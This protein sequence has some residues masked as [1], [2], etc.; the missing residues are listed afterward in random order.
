MFQLKTNTSYIGSWNG[1][2]RVFL[3]GDNLSSKNLVVFDSMEDLRVFGKIWNFLWYRK[4][5]EIWETNELL[6]FFNNN[7][8]VYFATRNIFELWTINDYEINKNSIELTRWEDYNP[9]DLIKKLADFSFKFSK[10]LSSFGSYNREWDIINIRPT[11]EDITI[12]ISFFW[13]EV[14]EV[15]VFDNNSGIY[16]K[17]DKIKISAKLVE[18]KTTKKKIIESISDIKKYFENSKI[19]LVS[20]D[21]YEWIETLTS[22]FEPIILRDTPTD[23]ATNLWITEL[24]ITNI[25]ELILTLKNP[26]KKKIYTK[27]VRTITNFIEYNNIS[28]DIE[29]VEIPA[30][31]RYLESFASWETLY[32]CDDILSDIFIKKRSRK[33]VAKNIDLLLEIKPWDCIVHIDHWVGVFKQIILKELGWIKREYVEIEYKWNDKLFVPISELHRIS[34]YIWKDNPELTWLNS[35]QWQK[36]IKSTEVEVERIAKELLEIYAKRNIVKW[37]AFSSFEDKEEE[38]RKSFPYTYTLDQETCIREILSDMN[39]SKPM[40]RLLVGDVWFGKTEVAMNAIYRSFLNKK[41]TA[42]ISPLVILAYEH[43]ESLKKRFT[44]FGV[45]IEILTRV[46]TTREESQVLKQLASWEIDCVIWTHRLLSPDIEFKNLGLIIIDEEHRF[47]VIDKEKLNKMRLWETGL[48]SRPVSRP[49]PLDILSLSATPIPRSLNFALNGIKD[50]SIISTPPPKKKPIKTLVAKWSDEIIT[51]SIDSELEK[52]WQVLFIHNRVATIEST[53]N[54][55]EKLLGKK[56]KIVTVH[57]QMN[58]IEVEDRIIDFRNRKYNILLSTTVIENGVNFY[59]ANTIII[60]WADSFWLSQLHQLRWRVWRWDRESSCYL[61][62]RKEWIPDDA[63]KRLV[64]IVNNS[65]LGAW[66]EI[67]MRDLEIRWAWD[68]L[69]IKQSGKSKETW[70]SLYIKLLEDKIEELKTWEKSRWIN[71]QIELNISYYISEDFFNTEAD[72]IHFFRNIESIE[73]LE[74]LEYAYKTFVEWNDKIPEEFNNLFL[75]LKTRIILS[76][77]WIESLKKVWQS[78]IF[79]LYKNTKVE[80]IKEFL[81]KFDIDDNFVLIT[82]HKIKVATEFY[83]SDKDFIDRIINAS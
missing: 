63:K 20:L 45:R 7:S 62:Y 58:G 12:K 34:K 40:D 75:V 54:Y 41:Q 51:K 9:E 18:S 3:V 6:N 43:Y 72:K 78:Y 66:F 27:N 56:A 16:K 26:T 83:S 61:V 42:F 13:N 48:D 31:M 30:S 46:S 57:G 74:D 65:H 50:I 36:I 55:L 77:Y 71:C 53:K 17:E 68:I 82:V 19:F 4:Y 8:W 80:I 5:F 49:A 59:N 73:T 38:F 35:T 2:S 69:W 15:L 39:K 37:Y 44:N 76:D 25:D 23:K 24:S 14:D 81:D 52:D 22:V 79:E 29:V 60:D 67:A 70:L 28:W 10:S 11:L 47:W 1:F 33:S 21:F 64:T 32:I